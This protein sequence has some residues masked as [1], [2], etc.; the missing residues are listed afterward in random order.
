MQFYC[1]PVNVTSHPKLV[2]EPVFELAV[3][4]SV[5]WVVSSAFRILFCRFH[6]SVR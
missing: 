3:N 2:S 5:A 6:V 4:V 1:V